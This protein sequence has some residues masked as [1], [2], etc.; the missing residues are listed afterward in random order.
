M[1][2]KGPID[3][4][5]DDDDSPTRG[6]TSAQDEKLNAHNLAVAKERG[7][8]L[9]EWWDKSGRHIEG[10]PGELL[11]VD[12]APLNAFFR[13]AGGVDEVKRR[14]SEIDP[15]MPPEDKLDKLAEIFRRP[16]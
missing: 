3:S 11:G 10:V 4:D 7:K 16:G 12:N 9:R 1:N 2:D 14:L 5:D 15:E 6:V 13:R 8:T